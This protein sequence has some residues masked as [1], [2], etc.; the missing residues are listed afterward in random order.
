MFYKVLHT[1]HQCSNLSKS[2]EVDVTTLLLFPEN[3]HWSYTA[4]GD[5]SPGSEF[6]KSGSSDPN[7]KHCKVAGSKHMRKEEV[8]LQGDREHGKLEGYM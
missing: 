2:Y 3:R 5:K 7:L 4:I 8:Q 1:L 6:E